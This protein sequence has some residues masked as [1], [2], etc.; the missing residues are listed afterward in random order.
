MGNCQCGGAL[1][2]DSEFLADAERYGLRDDVAIM[3]KCLMC[4]RQRRSTEV[5][6]LRRVGEPVMAAKRASLF[7]LSR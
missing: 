1:K 3:W 5:V 7:S 2:V 4:G 6:S